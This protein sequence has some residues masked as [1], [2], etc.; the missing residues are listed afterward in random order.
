MIVQW[1]IVYSALAE[2]LSLVPSTYII[3]TSG[4]GR[5][6]HSYTCVHTHVQSLSLEFEESTFDPNTV[7]CITGNLPALQSLRLLVG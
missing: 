5:H 7:P 2:K 4:C 1:L 3:N 6:L